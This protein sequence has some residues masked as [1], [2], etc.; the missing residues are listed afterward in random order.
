MRGWDGGV[1][2]GREGV[3]EEREPQ[4]VVLNPPWNPWLISWGRLLHAGSGTGGS[5]M[6][7]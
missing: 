7:P 2:G 4:G 5:E 3:R 6:S 1:F